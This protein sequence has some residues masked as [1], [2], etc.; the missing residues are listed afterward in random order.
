MRVILWF[1][2]MLPLV[3]GSCSKDR[4]VAGNGTIPPKNLVANE[5]I[6]AKTLLYTEWSTVSA[7]MSM[8][9]S[10]MR[11]TLITDLVSKCKNPLASLQAISDYDLAWSSLMYKFLLDSG[12]K[13]ASDLQAMSLDDFRNTVISLNAAHTN[14]SVS[15]L[16]NYGNNLN[17]NIAYSWWFYQNSATKLM[18]EK[19]NNVRGS[20]P[21]F[22][23][24]DSRGSGMDVLRI[25][26][27]DEDYTYLGISHSMV[28][29]GHFKLYLAGSNDLLTWTFISEMGDRAHQGDIEKWGKGYLVANEQDVVQGSNNIQIRYYASYS[30]LIVNNPSFSKSL[31]QTFSTLAEGTPDIRKVEGDSPASSYLLIGYHFYDHGIRDQQAFGI[32]HNFTEWRTWIDEISNYNIQEMGYLGNIGARSGFIHSGDYVLQEAQITSGD[33]SSWR[34]LFGNGAF[35]YTLHPATPLGSISFANPGIAQVNGVNSFAVTSFL[36]SQGNQS[37]E[38]GELLYKIDL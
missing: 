12:T 27:A 33:W 14:Y 17:L 18:I 7:I 3:C 25:V 24:K 9:R 28:S 38:P 32:L 10:E 19:F 35:Y 4:S 26:K 1:V 8:T 13:S 21:S 16:Q 34:L 15:K 37:G 31:P 22:D 23:K 29:D 5:N 6:L 11:N 20:A 36:P 2:L 30:D